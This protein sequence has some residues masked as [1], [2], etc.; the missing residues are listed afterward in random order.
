V[1]AAALVSHVFSV[2]AFEVINNSYRE[3]NFVGHYNTH[4]GI[5]MGNLFTMPIDM[6]LFDER[7]LSHAVRVCI[8]GI[9]VY[10]GLGGRFWS[11]SPSSLTHLGSFARN[12]F[13]LPASSRYATKGE[14]HTIEKLGRAIGC[15]TCGSRE[16]FGRAK[17][18]NGVRFI[19]DHMPP[20]SVV[21]QINS[22][23]HRK[24]LGKYGV[25]K[26]RFFPQCV[27]CSNKQ[28][29]ILSRAVL[30][31]SKNLSTSGGGAN[32]H[33]HGRRLRKEHLAGG[34]LVAITLFGA[35]DQDIFRNGGGNRARFKKMQVEVVEKMT[36]VWV[37]TRKII[38]SKV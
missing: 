30:E 26:Q 17:G 6:N 24:F 20:Q 4:T 9:V 12:I 29:G 10:K 13:S 31:T 19:A 11:I 28:G 23:W 1:A 16:I 37:Y 18:Q 7:N 2:K 14:R 38:R 36:D 27:T 35:K 22:R 33:L 3:G 25:V 8:V 34:A 21:K 5:T 32:A 15:H